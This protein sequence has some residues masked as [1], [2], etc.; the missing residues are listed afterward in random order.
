M[1]YTLSHQEFYKLRCCWGLHKRGGQQ[2]ILLPRGW[3]KTDLPGI[4]ESFQRHK[5]WRCP[6][7]LH[8]FE[9]LK[10]L[11]FITS[12]T[13][14]FFGKSHFT[15]MKFL[16]TCPP[17]EKRLQ[18][19]HHKWKKSQNLYKSRFLLFLFIEGD[20][21]KSSFSLFYTHSFSLEPLLSRAITH[22]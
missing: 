10:E 4:N 15:S 5:V 7:K 8:Y 18:A 21:S 1:E 12:E 6:V 11:F 22:N 19:S 17:K 20:V 13:H 16:K 9:V 14:T 3:G 2:A